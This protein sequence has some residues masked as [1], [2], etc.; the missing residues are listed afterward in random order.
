MCLRIL[1]CPSVC[2]D[3]YKTCALYVAKSFTTVTFIMYF[4]INQ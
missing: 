1:Y 2:F 3:Q 4:K